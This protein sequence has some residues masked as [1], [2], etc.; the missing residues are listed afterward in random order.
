M[1]IICPSCHSPVAGSASHVAVMVDDCVYHLACDAG[2]AG[3][4]Y[5]VTELV[6]YDARCVTKETAIEMVRNMLRFTAVVGSM[7]SN[8]GSTNGSGWPVM[9]TPDAR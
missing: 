5:V 1:P 2:L 6:L 8:D 7:V 4:S 9:I 3:G